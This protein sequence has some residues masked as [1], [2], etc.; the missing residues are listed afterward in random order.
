[1][2]NKKRG[3]ETSE[4]NNRKKRQVI[5]TN[6]DDGDI[7]VSCKLEN[8]KNFSQ[9]EE[10]H[11]DDEAGAGAGGGVFDFPWLKNGD[12]VNFRAEIDEYLDNSTFAASTSSYDY[13]DREICDIDTTTTTT[14]TT[15]NSCD[16]VLFDEKNMGL[17]L[18]LDLDFDLIDQYFTGTTESSNDDQLKM[19]KIED[20]QLKIE[21]NDDHKK[22]VEPKDGT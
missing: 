2:E 8:T 17:E 4:N 22:L 9:T 16:N 3:R 14:T 12:D 5:T 7:D 20:E 19:K 13:D 21:V 6:M 1:M 11:H 10:Y 18:D 15:S